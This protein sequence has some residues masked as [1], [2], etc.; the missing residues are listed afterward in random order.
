MQCKCE[1]VGK[2]YI[3]VH[4]VQSYILESCGSPSL[5]NLCADFEHFYNCINCGTLSLFSFMVD[6]IALCVSCIVT[7]FIEFL[8]DL[9]L[10]VVLQFL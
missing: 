1:N 7:S 3:S 2:I 6:V 10:Y 9:F 8:C 5:F 4:V